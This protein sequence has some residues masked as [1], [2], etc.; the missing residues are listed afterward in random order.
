M[1]LYHLA[2]GLLAAGLAIGDLAAEPPTPAEL[3]KI[4]TN[5]KDTDAVRVRAATALAR[6]GFSPALENG[7]PGLL[8]VLADPAE[9][10]R[11][12]ERVLWSVR[13]YLVKSRDRASALKT[14]TA[15]VSERPDKE[16]KMLRYDSAYLLA[17]FAAAKAPEKALDVLLEFLK[18]SSI[19]IY[20]GGGKLRG[21]GRA[22]AVDAL[23]SIGPERVARRPQLVAQLRAL[24]A[25]QNTL[26]NLREQLQSLMPQ[27]EEV[28]KKK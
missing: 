16:N 4:V 13:H 23:S 22:M 11:L 27:L 9:S 10:A 5:Q 1:R 12:R 24:N 2:C 6:R 3:V 28:L 7:M 26:P 8:R 14:L 18:D 20:V 19:K 15:V 17:M 21:D 25:D